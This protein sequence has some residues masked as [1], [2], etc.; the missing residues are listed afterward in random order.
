MSIQLYRELTGQMPIQEDIKQHLSRKAESMRL[1]DPMM[2]R[3]GHRNL[4]TKIG[5]ERN[6]P[7][8]IFFLIVGTFHRRRLAHIE[9]FAILVSGNFNEVA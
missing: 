1:F 6:A 2:I 3:N 5:C 4:M 7:N 9:T 8:V